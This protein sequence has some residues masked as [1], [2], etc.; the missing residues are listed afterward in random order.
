MK[1]GHLL[2]FALILTFGVLAPLWAE[3]V[4]YLK[5]GSVIHGTITEEVPGKKIKIETKDGNVFVYRMGQIDKITHTK[6]AD[7]ADQSQEGVAAAAAPV[8]AVPTA[9]PNDP[10]A[11]FSKF[12]MTLNAGFWAPYLNTEFNNALE[13][14]TGTNSY[15]YLAGWI[16]GGIGLAWFTNNVALKWNLQLSYQPNNYSTDWYW[17][18]YYAG[19]TEEDTALITVGSELEADLGFDNV[20]NSNNVTTFYIPFMAGVWAQ[21]WDYSDSAGNSEVFSNTTT[22]FG[23]GIGVRGFDSSNFLWDLQLAYRW[24]VRGNYL[25]DPN[26]ARI[27]DGKGSYIDANVSGMDLNFTIGFLFQ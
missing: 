15:D 5:D 17:G 4:V 8:K 24:A 26:G 7:A 14:S 6:P 13:K 19:T 2:G 18:G 27:P 11:R 10:H 16:K 9:E 25:T 21:E 20:V 22:D 3:D 1:K 12:G 23:T